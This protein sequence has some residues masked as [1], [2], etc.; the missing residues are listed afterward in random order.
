MFIGR[1]SRV[2]WRVSLA[3]GRPVMV[4]VLA[5]LV[6]VQL[7]P[8][9]LNSTTVLPVSRYFIE[10]EPED[11]PVKVRVNVPV[12]VAPPLT[13]TPLMNRPVALTVPA[14]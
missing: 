13:G 2:S 9:L 10:Q 14:P 1:R 4:N 3:A 12:V 6:P 8:E 5:L 11:T 7:D